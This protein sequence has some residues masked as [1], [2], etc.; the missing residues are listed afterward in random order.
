MDLGPSV[1]TVDNLSSFYRL[2]L[3]DVINSLH[4]TIWKNWPNDVIPWWQNRERGSKNKTSIPVLEVSKLLN[5]WH[6]QRDRDA[7][8]YRETG[9]GGKERGREEESMV[10]TFPVRVC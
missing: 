9:V 2:E 8:R 6:R 7:E 3:H 10:Y 5:A 4:E 1:P